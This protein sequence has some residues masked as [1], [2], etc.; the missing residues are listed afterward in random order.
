MVKPIKNFKKITRG[1]QLAFLAVGILLSSNSYAAEILGVNF[2]DTYKEEGINLSLQGTGLK[3]KFFIKAFVAGFYKSEDIRSNALG[4]YPKKIEVEYFVSI[5]AKKMN[6]FTVKSMKENITQNEFEQIADQI[7][8]MSRYFVNLKPG[9][10]YSLTF[11]PGI[12]TKF[13]HNGDLVGTIQGETF[14]KA[15]FST[16]LGNKPFDKKLKKQILGAENN[17]TNKGKEF[18]VRLNN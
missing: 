11:I 1:T 13:V 6:D 17:E 5:P 16:W 2:Q 18:I 10:R 14:A 9:D 4:K 7:S 15:L 3:T 8:L 12:G